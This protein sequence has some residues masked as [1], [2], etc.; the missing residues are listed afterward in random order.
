MGSDNRTALIVHPSFGLMGGDFVTLEIA[1]AL[2]DD[3]YRVTVASENKSLEWTDVWN[4]KEV[5]DKCEHLALPHPKFNR[6]R[7]FQRLVNARILCRE[8]P[9]V[10]FEAQKSSYLMPDARTISIVYH[11]G[12]L[13]YYWGNGLSKRELYYSFV[14][15]ARK[16]M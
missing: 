9:D 5:M 11:P 10:V 8:K 16:I 12:D 6:A 3:G 1:K 2:L 7:S 15:N 4:G 14:R 13:L